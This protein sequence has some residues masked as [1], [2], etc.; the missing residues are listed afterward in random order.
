MALTDW[1]ERDIIAPTTE[2]EHEVVKHV[3]RKMRLTPTGEMDAATQAALRGVQRFFGLQV[4][5]TLD[6]ATAA[7]V[8]AMR[9]NGEADAPPQVRP[10][11]P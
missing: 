1:F 2:A 8:D 9:A 10:E 3:Q 11:G 5:G 6:R 4:H 7:R